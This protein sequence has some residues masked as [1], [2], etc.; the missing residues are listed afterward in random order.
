MKRAPRSGQQAGDGPW[1]VKAAA[2]SGGRHI[3]IF[4]LVNLHTAPIIWCDPEMGKLILK[5]ELQRS[6]KMFVRGCEKFLP[7]LA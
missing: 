3:S 7:A 5:K 2:G 4:L 6:Q 1:S